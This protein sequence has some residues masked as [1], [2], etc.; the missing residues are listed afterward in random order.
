MWHADCK[1]RGLAVGDADTL[2]AATAPVHGI[3]IATGN[4][5]H[6]EHFSRLHVE[7]WLMRQTD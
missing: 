1:T 5:R 7:N 6:F 4:V 2:I 3:G